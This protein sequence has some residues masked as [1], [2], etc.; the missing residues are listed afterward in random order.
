MEKMKKTLFITGWLFLLFSVISCSDDFLSKN[1]KSSY[2]CSDTLF[3]DLNRD[4]IETSLHLPVNVDAA[5]RIYSQPKWFSFDA[6]HGNVQDGNVSLSISIIRNEVPSFQINSGTLILD[7]DGIG[8]MYI[9]ISYSGKTSNSSSDVQSSVSSLSFESVSTLNFTLSHS[10]AEQITW[11]I[12]GMPSWL[13]LSETSGSFN[14]YGSKTISATVDLSHYTAGQQ[15]NATIQLN[16][17]AGTMHLIYVHAVVSVITQ[18]DTLSIKTLRISGIVTDAEYNH[19]TGIMAICT[20]S[21]N[22]LILFNS[23][24]NSFNTLPL[25]RTP[26][27]ISLSED[28]NKAVIGYTVASVSYVDI[29]TQTITDDFTIDVMPFDIVLGGNGW[30]YIA[31][32]ED[33]WIAFRSLNLTSGQLILG[34]NMSTMYEKTTL[35][36]IPGKSYLVGSRTTLSP[37]GILIFD[38]SKGI[39][40]DTVSYYHASIGK[41]SI[42]A[43]GSKLYE[44]NKNVY[45]L[46]AYDYLFHPYAPPVCG[47]F[48]S[49]LNY[50]TVFEDCP[51]ITSIFVSGYNGYYYSQEYSSLIEQYNSTNLN[52]IKTYNTAPVYIKSGGV[53]TPYDTEARFIFVNKD[54]SNIYALKNLKSSYSK[55][56][57]TIEVIKAGN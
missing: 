55:D 39:A 17:N 27:C 45:T 19:E 5:Y 4:K 52:K 51:S 23:N 12:T 21:P 38:I 14:G 10:S 11:N 8:L 6:M 48:E 44:G 22:A 3:V 26:Y 36:K 35:R 42:S 47:Q 49:A 16:T 33:Q 15:L 41:Y 54:G 9:V 13:T 25:T 50:L 28:G 32:T 29:T 31:A 20:K 30:C 18:P 43:D 56:Y 24:T 7:V 46:P 34:K 40:S 1:K 2:A 57:W 53:S 37:A